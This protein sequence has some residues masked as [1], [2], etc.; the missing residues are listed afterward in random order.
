MMTQTL[1]LQDVLLILTQLIQRIL[2]LVLILAVLS[3]FLVLRELPSLPL[4]LLLLLLVVLLRPVLSALS[5]LLLVL[6]YRRDHCA[7]GNTSVRSGSVSSVSCWNEL[8]VISGK[9][10]VGFSRSNGRPGLAS[11]RPMRFG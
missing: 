2:L 7:P 4:P 8:E 9:L 1:L 6:L 11:A 5:R 3:L 10:F